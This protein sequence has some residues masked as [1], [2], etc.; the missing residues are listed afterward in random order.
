MLCFRVRENA[1]PLKHALV[2]AHRPPDMR[3][4]RVRENAAPLKHGVRALERRINHR[5]RVRENAA[6]LKLR[7]FSQDPF[8]TGRFPRS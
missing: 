2:A 5:F 7:L 4:F 3:S 8:G 1:A 6:P